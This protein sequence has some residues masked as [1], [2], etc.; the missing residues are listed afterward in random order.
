VGKELIDSSAINVG[1]RT[2]AFD[3]DKAVIKFTS[4]WLNNAVVELDIE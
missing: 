2:L 3:P 1:I 4:L